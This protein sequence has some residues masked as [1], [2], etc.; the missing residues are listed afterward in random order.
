[1]NVFAG[2]YADIQQLPNVGIWKILQA[3]N[4]RAILRAFAFALLDRALRT[5]Q[6]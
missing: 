2:M 6:D 3:S 4:S 5:E 1:M